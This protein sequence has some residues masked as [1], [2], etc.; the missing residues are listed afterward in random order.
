MPFIIDP[1]TKVQG[2]TVEEYCQQQRR[3]GEVLVV[4]LV[5]S[6]PRRVSKSGL[7]LTTGKFGRILSRPHQL[8][9][10]CCR[11]RRRR[12][13]EQLGLS[14]DTVKQT[15]LFKAEYEQGENL[16]DVVETLVQ[17][18]HDE[19]GVTD[20]DSLK[21]YLVQDHGKG[22]G[23]CRDSLGETHDVWDTWSPLLCDPTSRDDDDD[24][25]D[26]SQCHPSSST[27]VH[28]FRCPGC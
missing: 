24:D 3:W 4:G 17:I 7:A 5:S 12:S 21:D 19:W 10:Y 1:N 23:P 22:S 6:Y 2:E 16:S 25:T 15:P 18:A 13:D 20:V 28:I 9:Q 27:T 8:I 11:R 26:E 14:S